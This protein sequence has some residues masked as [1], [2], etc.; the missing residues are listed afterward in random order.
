MYKFLYLTNTILKAKNCISLWNSG[1]YVY[2]E[3]NEQ[4]WIKDNIV[5]MT[6]E[7]NLWNFLSEK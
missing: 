2:D 3:N 1:N 7:T 5:F 4:N 6:N